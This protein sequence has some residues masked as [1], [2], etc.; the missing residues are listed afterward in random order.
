M[1]RTFSAI[2]EGDEAAWEETNWAE[3]ASL[4]GDLGPAAVE[5]AAEAGTVVGGPVVVAAAAGACA[6]ACAGAGADSEISAGAEAPP[7]GE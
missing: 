5:G 3:L 2:V 4:E 7:G 6:G 1:L